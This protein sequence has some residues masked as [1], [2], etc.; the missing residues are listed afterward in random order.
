MGKGRYM[1]PSLNYFRDSSSI[2]QVAHKII[3]IARDEDDNGADVTKFYLL[4][5]DDL[6]RIYILMVILI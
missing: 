2:S 3:Q 4:N 1:K 6:Y 5:L